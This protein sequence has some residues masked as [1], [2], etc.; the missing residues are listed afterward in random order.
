MTLA[1]SFLFMDYFMFKNELAIQNGVVDPAGFCG[2][3]RNQN[4]IL[5]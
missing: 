1:D 4:V 5:Q 3:V 2:G